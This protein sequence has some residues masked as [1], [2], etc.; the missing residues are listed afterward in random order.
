YNFMIYES[1]LFAQS[2]E[3]SGYR[4]SVVPL[5]L[6]G[7]TM[8]RDRANLKINPSAEN[9]CSGMLAG[10]DDLTYVELS[11]IDSP[12][13]SELSR[14]MLPVHFFP[15]DGD[16]AD[17][18]TGEHALRKGEPDWGV[19]MQTPLGSNR[20]ILYFPGRVHSVS[21]IVPELSGSISA[22][23]W[24]KVEDSLSKRL[25]QL[26][27]ESNKYEVWIADDSIW[28]DNSSVTG[29]STAGFPLSS[30]W[31]CITIV[32]N[33]DSNTLSLY[34]NGK[35]VA[36]TAVTVTEINRFVIGGFTGYVGNF[37]VWDRTLTSEEITARYNHPS[38]GMSLLTS[39]LSAF[40]S[41][42]EPVGNQ[43]G[44]FT[45]DNGDEAFLVAPVIPTTSGPA[46]PDAFN[47]LEQ[48]TSITETAPTGRG[49]NRRTV[50]I[51]FGDAA[52][53]PST[54]DVSNL[55]LK[56]IRITTHVVSDL[57]RRFFVGGPDMLL[58]LASQVTPELPFA[59]F[60][61]SEQVIAPSSRLL[62]FGGAYGE[63]FW[64]LFFYTPFLIANTLSANQRFQMA[65]K[66]YQYIF[67]PTQSIDDDKVSGYLSHI[68]SEGPV[69][70][71]PL[72][73]NANDVAGDNDGV[74]II[75]QS[76]IFNNAILVN[77]STRQ[78]FYSPDNY[79]NNIEVTNAADLNITA[80]ITLEGWCNLSSIGGDDSYIIQKHVD[81]DFVDPWYVYRLSVK[82]GVFTF[83]LS[84]NGTYAAVTSGGSK[85]KLYEW[86][87]VAGT[88][89]GQ[90]LQLYVNGQPV[91]SQPLAQLSPQPPTPW[92]IATSG[93]P[94]GLGGDSF[95]GHLG[96]VCIWDKA[97]PPETINRHYRLTIWL[98][99][100]DRFWRFRPFVNH[101][102]DSLQSDLTNSQ[103]I[104]VYKQ[105]PFDPDALARLRPGANEKG[106]VMRYVENLLKWGNSLFAQYTWETVTEATVLYTEAL[107]LLGPL[108]QQ[109]GDIP[110]P[111][112]KTALDFVKEYGSAA[113]IPQFL[114]QLE[115][116]VQYNPPATS[117]ELPA[118]P[119][120][121]LNSYFCVPVDKMLLALWRAVDTQ[122]YKIRHG[123]NIKGQP[124]PLP[125]F[126][127]PL[128][129][130]A[131]VKAGQGSLATPSGSQSGSPSIPYFR[132]SYLIDRAK[133]FA[134]QVIQLGSA[135]LGALERQDA[136]QLALIQNSNEAT[137]LNLTT[138]IKQ[139]QIDELEQTAQALEAGLAAARQ[140][141]QTYASWL[142]G[143]PTSNDNSA[144]GQQNSSVTASWSESLSTAEET[145]LV[146]L[147]EA[148]IMHGTA[149]LMRVM[150]SPL[151]LIPDIFGLAD[152]G[153]SFGGS[154][155]AVAGS[156]DSVGGTL[157]ITS[158]LIGIV[159][160]WQRRDQEWLLQYR[161]A[162]DDVE[163]IQAQIEANQTA[164][165]SAQ[166]D[167]QVH[168]E[169]ITQ[170][171]AIGNFY[172]AKFTSEQ[173]YQWMSGRLSTI[174]F[175]SYQL[176]FDLAQEAQMAFQYQNNSQKNYLNYGAWD[177]VE[178]GL[179]AGDT[180]MLSLDQLQK[181]YID[182]SIRHLEIEKTVSLLQT[183][184]E[185]VVA[186]KTKGKC[187]FALTER[188]FDYDFPGHYNRKITSVSITIPAIVGPYQNIHAT[189]TQTSNRVVLQPDINGVNYL[190]TGGERGASPPLSIR[191]NWNVK[192]QVAL[193][194]GADDSG[195]V[196]LDFNDPRY[197]PFEG[198]GAISTWTLE[199]PQAA[200]AIDFNTISDVIIKLNYTAQ[201]GGEAFR[202]YVVQQESIEY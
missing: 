59:R 168:Q 166:R 29:N 113:K 81:G 187:S 9:S 129:P 156:L 67:N 175:Q 18:I 169:Q 159:G 61:P 109:A 121:L 42:V 6:L 78:V 198:T 100:Q 194:R 92:A 75:K 162:S 173:L 151:Y 193:S 104:A 98:S 157:G 79:D 54:F 154:V 140:R 96:D 122:L 131:L 40:T 82:Q 106:I 138:Q 63:Y 145:S 51:T 62:D 150:A 32:V 93:Q 28:A 191:T 44:W 1:L 20:L 50:A 183:D 91:A 172:K 176:A 186:L 134:S 94:V 202:N 108:P 184:P 201:D 3:G 68:N 72:N 167:L 174:Y 179:T 182:T 99:P 102:V 88:F 24:V 33:A 146:L 31:T 49:I 4:T 188:L 155:E 132:F 123:E 27:G 19:G 120:N 165:S 64:E 114:I 141:Q 90:Q 43:P 144:S 57:Q 117:R 86:Y 196:V 26:E 36:D 110:A 35:Y 158:Q 65:Q 147:D 8:A 12:A 41:R 85:A 34:Q 181:A 161:L 178:K 180:L 89:D 10:A 87:H 77:G 160:Q 7:S 170:N 11:L 116:G 45:F 74:L 46:N 47:S 56:F 69:S 13:L 143:K 76:P 101:T 55:K 37:A 83:S 133:D 5:W 22:E 115:H 197:L 48:I 38:N 111:P 163:Q 200:N 126:E 84:I 80:A 137:I 152:G 107:D 192:Q 70:Y 14:G 148:R 17:A 142:E 15:L 199:M 71:W 136:E 190:L 149:A 105:D 23:I 97:L 177:S 21:R 164:L 16:L 2:L 127:P 118:L 185:A 124:Q 119:F 60:T 128:N 73:G 195:L 135:L 139:D 66:W 125:L 171:Q 30:D 39:G 112:V 103:Q 25:L 52:A 130:A 58:S 189:L 153:M 95:Y 53:D